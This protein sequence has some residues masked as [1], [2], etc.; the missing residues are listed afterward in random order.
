MLAELAGVMG[1]LGLC[2]VVVLALRLFNKLTGN[3]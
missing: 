2:A 3:D 1:F